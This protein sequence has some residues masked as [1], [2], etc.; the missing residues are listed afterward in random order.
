MYALVLVAGLLGVAVNRR[1]PCDRA[2]RAGLAPVG[3]ARRWRRDRHAAALDL[4]RPS[5]CRSSLFVAV[6]AR[7]AGQH[8]LLLAAAR[9]PSSSV[10]ARRGRRGWPSDVAPEPGAPGGRLR[11]RRGHRRRPRRAARRHPA[12]A[13]LLEPVLEFFRAIPPPVLVPY[14]DAVPGIGTTDEDLGHRVRL[15]LADPAQHRRGRPR[16]R[17]GAR[18]TPAGRYR[19]TGVAAAAHAR[20]ARGQPADLHRLRQALSIGDHPDGDQ[21][22]VRRDRAASASRSSTSSAASQIPEM[23][24]GIILLGVLGF[25]LSSCSVQSSARAALVPRHAHPGKVTGMAQNDERR[26]PARSTAAQ[27]LRTADGRS[28]EAIGDL[29]FA[30]RQRRARLHRRPV[31]RRQDHAAAVRRRPA[32]RRPA[33]RSCSR[34]SRSPARR[35]GMAVV[36]QEYGRSLFPWLTVRRQRRAAARGKGRRARPSAR[37]LVGARARRGRPRRRARCYP[38]QLSGGMQQRVAIARAI[39]YEP[40]ILLMDEPFAAVDAQTR[41]ELEDLVRA[42]EAARRHRPVRHPRHRRGRLPGAAGA[43]ALARADRHP[44]R[45]SPSTCRPSATSSP[46]APPRFAELRTEVYEL[47]QRAK[48]TNYRNAQ[49]RL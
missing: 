43:R 38:W 28:V 42:V 21:R 22:D 27:G 12:A 6:V 25:A 20:A 7:H 1:V 3:A 44:A 30:S 16:H 46:P 26:R 5:R 33:A 23:W 15:R 34:A 37:A 49:G 41:A 4:R 48:H 13:A 40:Q 29:D 17:R 45:M 10:F 11:W 35:A 24:S 9:R 36:F 18:S 19:I 2:P 8:Q 39:A 47:I 31:G 32:R 14:H